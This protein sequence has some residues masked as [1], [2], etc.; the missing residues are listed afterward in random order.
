MK[1][2]SSLP[3]AI[4]LVG[5]SAIPARAQCTCTNLLL[6]STNAGYSQVAVDDTFVY[7]GDNAGNLKKVPKT[8]GAVIT[9]ATY[10]GNRV[11]TG[12]AVDATHIYVGIV[13]P[14]P[15][16]YTANVGDIAA[17]PKTGGAFTTLTTLATNV[18]YLDVD[19]TH[20][21]WDSYGYFPGPGWPQANGF[22]ARVPKAGGAVQMLATGLATSDNFAL[23]GNDVY[24]GETGYVS[25]AFTA[26]GIKK[27]PK[28]GGAVTTVYSGIA[29]Y[30]ATDVDYVYA[31]SHFAGEIFRV[32]KA[33][34]ARQNYL[35]GLVF[36]AQVR[37][38]DNHLYFAVDDNAGANGFVGVL[39]VT[40][41]ASQILKS[42]IPAAIAVAVDDCAVYS[43]GKD[44]SNVGTVHR[45][46]RPG[47]VT[48]TTSFSLATNALSVTEFG[49]SVTIQVNRTGDTTFAAS[50]RY[51]SADGTATAGSDY[52][53]SWAQGVLDFQPG[54]SNKTLI[55]PL[56]MADTLAE[57]DETF[58][59]F[60]YQPSLSAALG[61]PTN[62]TITILDNDRPGPGKP[63][64]NFAADIGTQ[65]SGDV[66][67]VARQGDGRLV[68]GGQFSSVNGTNR[69]NV[70]RVF[71]HGALDASFG[72]EAGANSAVYA[73][74]LQAD[75]QAVIAGAFSS[76]QGTNR[77]GCARL[78]TS[79]VLDTNFVPPKLSSFPI[80][81]ALVI[82]PDGKIIVGGNFAFGGTNLAR[83]NTNGAL[84]ATFAVSAGA[85]GS[86]YSLALQ[87]DGK[88]LVGGSFTSCN[89]Q[90]AT[91]LVRLTSSGAVD[92][93]FNAAVL[94][95][96]FQTSVRSILPL[97]DG[98][99]LIGGSFTNVNGVV[100][101]NL[102]RL[103]S[104]GGLD[105]NFVA[106]PNLNGAVMAM[107]AQADGKLLLGGGFNLPGAKGVARLQADGSHDTSFDVG[108][109]PNG[110]VNQLLLL[111]EGDVLVAGSFTL[112]NELPA[113]RL[114]VL[115]GAPAQPPAPA[116]LFFG[117]MAD[118]FRL[119]F[120]VPNGS[121]YVLEASSNLTG[122]TALESNVSTGADIT[123]DDPGVSTRSR[124]FYRIRMP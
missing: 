31:S 72:T 111:P 121:N 36:P 22:I 44:G 114:V 66:K 63:V 62:L 113:K 64:T 85:N 50:V 28:T 87:P 12:V 11:I 77:P 61:S 49:G 97:A 122:W 82:Q 69:N 17:V 16:G 105:T 20:V 32:P 27:V 107:A 54:E 37:R 33:G 58:A 70:A 79:G 53:S 19:G 91:N 96:Q 92:Q 106:A 15:Q 73:V 118:V 108:A 104:N 21:Y 98:R 46:C 41:G 74:A 51:N 117:R 65:F 67:A 18:I 40:S 84:D 47:V 86:I 101:S 25:P 89:G 13:G 6:Y 56:I 115:R 81:N 38:R 5:M 112:F 26:G 60:L 57:P 35:G 76:V 24:F 68:V 93:T 45:I 30:V 119:V 34:G 83:L 78:T 9:V 110:S 43:M 120:A 100:R 123:F 90:A 52:D 3:L 2:R 124:R 14:L 4:M 95:I 94:G 88:V 8:G 75:G 103:L 48:P 80:H 59:F 10:P 1:N 55:L 116:F 71:A 99:I 109:G 39:D 29:G 23:D 102:A 7:F 42:G